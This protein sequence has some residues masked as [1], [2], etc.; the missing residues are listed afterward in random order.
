MQHACTGESRE[1]GIEEEIDV[2]FVMQH[3]A[4]ALE[5]LGALQAGRNMMRSHQVSGQDTIEF[6][7]SHTLAFAFFPH[8]LMGIRREF[9]AGA[10]SPG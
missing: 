4:Q 10:A 3:P 8:W 9:G 5:I 1:G 6:A 2:N 7:V